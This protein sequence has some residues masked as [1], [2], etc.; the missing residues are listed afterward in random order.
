M[1]VAAQPNRNIEGPDLE[2]STE[3]L[4][5]GH[6]RNLPGKVNGTLFYIDYDDFQAQGFDGANITVRNAGSLESKGFELDVVYVPN[7]NLTLGTAVGYNDAEYDDFDTGEC[8][9]RQIV[10]I[11]GGNPFIPPN[12]VQDLTGEPLDNAPEWTVS[13]YAQ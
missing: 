1:H 12:C 13:S 11:T 8:T 3:G 4:T 5:V 10:E 2:N 7:A 9:V 6:G